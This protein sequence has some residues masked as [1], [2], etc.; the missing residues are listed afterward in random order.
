MGTKETDKKMSDQWCLI[1]S[2]PGVFTE[3]VDKVGVKGIQFE[4]VYDL[5][6][7]PK[8]GCHGLIF[9]FKC[10]SKEPREAMMHPPAGLFFAKQVIHNACA[11][12]AI[13]A[14]LLNSKL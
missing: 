7:V 13:L 10:P 11:T 14:V 2:D 1:E 5:D 4:E 8:D 6:M 9:L 3:L 12:Q